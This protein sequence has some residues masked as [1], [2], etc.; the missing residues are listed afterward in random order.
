MGFPDSAAVALCGRLPRVSSDLLDG[1]ALA[2]FSHRRPKRPL[3]VM[4]Y[5]DNSA[6]VSVS[7]EVFALGE[8]A[9]PSVGRDCVSVAKVDVPM[10]CPPP[11]RGMNIGT[12]LEA[13]ALQERYKT[14]MRPNWAN[15]ELLDRR[16]FRDI[17]SGQLMK[18]RLA[19]RPAGPS[20]ISRN[21]TR[22]LSSRPPEAIV[23]TRP[24]VRK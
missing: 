22:R 5:A 7:P 20:A 3:P 24:A 23:D 14:T 21:D 12:L 10:N 13:A 15:V 11:S 17:A 6:P 19:L 4:R 16:D 2:S 8:S 18:K 1:S 9:A